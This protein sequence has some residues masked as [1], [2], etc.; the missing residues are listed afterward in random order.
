MWGIGSKWRG[1]YKQE[2]HPMRKS[3]ALTLMLTAALGLAAC[4]KK[5]EDK[6]QD[7]QQHAEQAQQK[8]DDA[9]SKMNDAAKE[10]A[11]AAQDSADSQKAQ[12]EEQNDAMKQKAPETAPVPAQKQ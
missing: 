5:S 11:K 2:K 3:L 7:A 10:N 1:Y 4:D 12:A 6:A 8:M 9:Q